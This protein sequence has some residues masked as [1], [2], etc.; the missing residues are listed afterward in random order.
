MFKQVKQPN[1]NQLDHQENMETKARNYTSIY[2][3]SPGCM[4]IIT[5]TFLQ[6]QYLA[7]LSFILVFISFSMASARG[8]TRVAVRTRART[9]VVEQIVP[10]SGWTEDSAAHYLVVDLPE[11]RKE[12]VKLQVNE[13]K[14]VHFRLTFPEPVNSNMD[15]IAGNFD[16]GI[17]YVIVPKQV[18]QENKESEIAKTGNGEVERAEENDRHQHG[19]GEVE[20]AEENDRHRHTPN[21]DEGRR[22]SSQHGNHTEQEVNRNESEHIRDFSEQVI[23]NWEQES[24]L[25]SAVEVLRKNKGIVI[26]AVIAF[27][28]GFVRRVVVEVIDARNLLPKDGQGS[29]SPYVVVDF[30]G[31]RKRTTTRFKE[32]NPVWNEPL[33]F[34]VSDPDNMEFEELEVELYND[35]KFGNGSGRK[36]HFLGRVKLYGTQFSRRGEEALVYYTLEKRSVFSWIRGEIGLRIYYYDDMLL[37]DDK[38][39]LPQEEEQGERLEQNK[40]PPGVVVLLI[41]RALWLWRNRRRRWCMSRRIRLCRKCVT[42]LCRKCSS[43]PR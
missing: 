7:I 19:N 25:R 40:P 35:K 17:L 11:F 36:N 28:L 16:G 4:Q 38:P 1:H 23:K 29:S 22:D 27:S 39:P 18:K 37:E 34:I 9:P 24:M 20:R 14:R 6:Y 15:K 21:A 13:W 32:L 5:L 31:Q 10:N 30:D 8:T 12:E 3:P 33:E 26:T 42:V 41:R 2:T 43:S